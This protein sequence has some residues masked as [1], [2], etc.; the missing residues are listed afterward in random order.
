MNR[1]HNKNEILAI[2][3]DIFRKNGYAN[4]GIN[5]ILKAAK[6]PKGSFYNFFESKEDFV[7]QALDDYSTFMKNMMRPVLSDY[8]KSPL[9]RLR[10][11]YQMIIDSNE[12]E[13]LIGGCF[14]NTISQEVAGINDEIAKSADKNFYRLILLI[15]QTIAE[16]QEKGEIRD[17]FTPK[18][19]AEYLHTGF[20]GAM[21]RMKANRTSNAMNLFYDIAFTFIRR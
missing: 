3:R 21:S 2:G 11:I 6:I 9:K 15:G 8:T 19:L 12:Q 14:V 13:G 4:T 20:Y 18:E 5:E 7:I 17:D 16:G 1:K 10:E